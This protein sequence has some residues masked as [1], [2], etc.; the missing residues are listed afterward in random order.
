MGG[1]GDVSLI[2]APVICIKE[3]NLEG[4]QELLK[5]AKDFIFTPSKSI[6]EYL[7]V[8]MVKSQPKPPWIFFRKHIAPQLIQLGFCNLVVRHYFTLHLFDI[9][10][11]VY[12][13]QVDRAYQLLR[14]FKV[15]I[16]LSVDMPNTLA[17]SRIPLAFAAI[18]MIFSSVPGFAPS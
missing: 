4:S 14:F 18:E 12:I 15:L 11:V 2:A 7:P 3:G 13:E 16:T 17:V 8:L 9:G 1:I 10:M 5:P 6:S